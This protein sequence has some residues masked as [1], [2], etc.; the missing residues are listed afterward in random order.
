ME[1][2]NEDRMTN[3]IGLLFITTTTSAEQ[4]VSS[5]SSPEH[6]FNATMMHFRSILDTNKID[7][8]MAHIKQ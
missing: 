7:G 5:H 4:S 2:K 3:S 1:M 6:E 8:N